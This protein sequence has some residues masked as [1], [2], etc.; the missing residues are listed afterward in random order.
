M[1]YGDLYGRVR[2]SAY[3]LDTEYNVVEGDR[4]L[5]CYTPGLDFFTL[6]WACLSISAIPVPVVPVDPFNAT[7]DA[8]MKLA[9]IVNDCRPKLLLTC[10]EY[11]TAI[12]GAK[13]FLGD[14]I[15]TNDNT[16]F[17]IFTCNWLGTD[18]WIHNNSNNQ[19]YQCN[20]Y[21]N[22]PNTIAFLQYTSGSTSTP[23]GM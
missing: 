1:T 16:T 8:S 15:N 17:N 6:F 2:N 21:N 10:N 19:L 22:D 7:S 20:K 14:K 4:V 3:V 23:K 9:A 11:I 12:S 18:E 5:L 13:A